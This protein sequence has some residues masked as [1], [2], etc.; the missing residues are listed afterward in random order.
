MV[1]FFLVPF[2]VDQQHAHQMYALLDVEFECNGHPRKVIQKHF[3]FSMGGFV[4]ADYQHPFS[5]SGTLN[6]QSYKRWSKTIFH[7]DL[8][9]RI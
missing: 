7:G 5:R 8:N 4:R 2:L 9:R 3:Q 6:L 1:R